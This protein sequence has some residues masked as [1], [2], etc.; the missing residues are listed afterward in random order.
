MKID[1]QKYWDKDLCPI[2]NGIIFANSVVKMLEPKHA[3]EFTY[4]PQFSGTTSIEE[5]NSVDDLKL[6]TICKMKSLEVEEANLRIY[7]GEGS[8][9]SEGFV[10]VCDIADDKLQWIAYFDYSNPMVKVEYLNGKIVSYSNLG[11]KWE[12]NISTPENVLVSLT[13]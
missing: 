8:W 10:A 12:F 4:I 9:G 6:T 7:C 13:K 11:H 2:I 5:I 3:D 1:I